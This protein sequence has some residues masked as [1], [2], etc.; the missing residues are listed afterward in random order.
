MRLVRSSTA[1]NLKAFVFVTQIR[2]SRYTL[3]Q[4]Q[5]DGRQERM[6]PTSSSEV[7]GVCVCV[8]ACACMR[9]RLNGT[10]RKQREISRLLKSNVRGF[11]RGQTQLKCLQIKWS[12]HCRCARPASTVNI[13][14]INLIIVY[15]QLI[16]IS[17]SKMAGKMPYVNYS[18]LWAEWINTVLTVTP[19]I[20]VSFRN[21]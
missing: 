6:T 4:I 1:G 2:K 11:K 9:A 12:N 21:P 5:P 16:W 7:V 14:T 17:S 13:L 20:S 8:R 19:L 15:F 3:R 18:T 10:G